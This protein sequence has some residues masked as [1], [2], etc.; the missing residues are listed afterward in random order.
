MTVLSLRDYQHELVGKVNAH[1]SAGVRNVLMRLDTGGG[2]TRIFSYFAAIHNGASAVI[3]HRNEIVSQISMALAANGVYH[4]LICSAKSRRIICAMHMR[5][6]G[7]VFVTAVAR[8]T[9]ASAQT[10]VKRDN[11]SDWCKSVTLWIVDEG[12]HLTKG[13][14]WGKCVERFTHPLCK[15]LI[16]TATPKRADGK[17]L[18]RHADGYAD[19][20][21][22]G[23]TGRWLMDNGYLSKYKIAVANSHLE[24]YLGDV[25][26]GGD[27]SQKQISEASHK[28]TIVGDVV[29]SY[30]KHAWGK[31]GITFATDVDTANKMAE[32]YRQAGVPA[33]VLTG[34]TDIDVRAAII[35]RLE[36]R[37]LWQIVAVDVVS[38][39][40]DLPMCEVVTLARPTASLAVH[41]QQF[42]R[43][44]RPFVTKP[45]TQ[46]IDHVGNFLRHGG[47]P[48]TPRI[49]SLDR[50][51]K[52]AKNDAGVIKLRICLNVTCGQPYEAFLKVCPCCGE[53][54]PPPAGRGSPKEVDGELTLLDESVLAQLRGDVVQANLTLDDYRA[55]LLANYAPPMAVHAHVKKHANRLEAITAV[56]TSMAQWGGI[57][58]ALGRSD[59]EIQREF[60]QRFGIDVLS[61]QAVSTDDAVKLILRITEDML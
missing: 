16:P 2:K 40:F 19:V 13:S 30:R 1:W 43:G 12:H 46:F 20:M 57:R 28:S 14:V 25:T 47:G 51:D 23:P 31:I 21:V 49:W 39:G 48:D 35:S 55:K 17:G 54:I 41:L 36:R 34:E 15:G 53:P 7:K 58:H 44:L 4:T 56:R 5:K 18:G 8:C 50:R 59:A 6:F 38:E 10:L 3:A 29:E 61:A 32:R 45:F 42:G 33:E 11:L 26:D 9:A 60:Y 37:E 27:W 52:R 22:E 24:Q